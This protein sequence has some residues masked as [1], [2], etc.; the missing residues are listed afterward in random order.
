MEKNDLKLVRV[1][2]QKAVKYQKTEGVIL[3]ID[4]GIQYISL[5]YHKILKNHKMIPS[6]Y[7]KGNC[8]DTYFY[9]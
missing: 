3:Q 8:L 5:K 2:V 9:G 7:R 4:Q 6:M 1:T